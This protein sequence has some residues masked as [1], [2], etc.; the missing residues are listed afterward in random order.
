MYARFSAK[1]KT[2]R[3][4]SLAWHDTGIFQMSDITKL[5]PIACNTD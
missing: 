2:P 1:L 3:G 4:L 5:Q